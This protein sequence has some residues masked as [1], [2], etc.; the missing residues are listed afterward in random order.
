MTPEAVFLLAQALQR[1]ERTA[2]SLTTAPP[3]TPTTQADL[4]GGKDAD[5]Q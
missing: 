5:Q 4:F 1:T 3:P 2:R